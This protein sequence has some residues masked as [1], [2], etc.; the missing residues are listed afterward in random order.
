MRTRKR[1]DPAPA[2]ASPL[3]LFEEVEE[4]A[5]DQNVNLAIR[6]KRTGSKRF[7]VVETWPLR[8]LTHEQALAATEKDVARAIVKV[9]AELRPSE[10]ESFDGAAIKARLI[11]LGAVAV[12]LAPKTIPEAP[13]EVDPIAR[14]ETP[15]AA[16]DRWFDGLPAN[17]DAADRERARELAHQLVAR[18]E[19]NK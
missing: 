6:P 2:A 5:G 19:L 11:A 3:E 12:V 9:T 1:K 10:R 13:K 18:A 14:A 17:V 16:I 15:Q 4:L 8:Q 7:V